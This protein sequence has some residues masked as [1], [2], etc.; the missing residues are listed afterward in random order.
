MQAPDDAELEELWKSYYKSIFN[1]A[2]VKVKAMQAEMPKKYWKHLPE[3]ELIAGLIAGGGRRVAGMMQEEPLPAR[4]MAQHSYIRTLQ[5]Q[6]ARGAAATTPGDHVGQPLPV[7][8]EAARACRACPLHEQATATVFGEGPEE[9]RIMIVGEQPGDQEDLAGRV[10]IGPAGQ[11]L[12]RAMTAAGLARE[13]V[14]LTNAVKH[15]K[16]R[17]EGTRRLHQSPNAGEVSKCRPWLLAEL[18]RVKPE[19]LVCLGATAAKS[20]IDPGF[21]ILEERGMVARPD[22]APTVI[23]TVHPAHL[24]RQG[25]DAGG[26]EWEA[27]V[28]DLRWAAGG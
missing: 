26:P 2:R 20:L 28:A 24:L 10:F 4:D 1:P 12:H 15:F 23:A 21:R 19:V 22:L 13:E 16:W 8:R 3:A 6:N 11:L 18:L 17:R 5:E 7:L 27:F 14:Y 25:T 9:A